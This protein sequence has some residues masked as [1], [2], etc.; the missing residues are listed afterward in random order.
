MNCHC[1]KKNK[2]TNWDK[3]YGICDKCLID[4]Q[5]SMSYHIAGKE[6]TQGEYQ[7]KVNK[8]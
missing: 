5:L 7:R 8:T 4:I 3:N 1:C 2:A 6:V